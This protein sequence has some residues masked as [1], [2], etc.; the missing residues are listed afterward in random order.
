MAMVR[1]DIILKYK[2]NEEVYNCLIQKH[3]EL[4][5]KKV[6]EELKTQ[7]S[8]RNLYKWVKNFS[9]GK[10]IFVNNNN[11]NNILYDGGHIILKK[12]NLV[13]FN[14]YTVIKSLLSI[15]IKSENNIFIG[16][17]STN[18]FSGDYLDVYITPQGIRLISSKIINSKECIN[19][20]NDREYGKLHSK[21]EEGIKQ[22]NKILNL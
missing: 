8:V 12:E 1:N 6:I 11:N 21:I 15:K 17:V 5:M 2:A 10:K 7:L 3:L 14:C 18:N 4:N 20:L 22:V 16:I 9:M 19:L 13:D